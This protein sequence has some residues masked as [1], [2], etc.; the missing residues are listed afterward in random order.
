MYISGSIYV[1]MFHFIGPCRTVMNG[2]ILV[3][4]WSVA[5][6]VDFFGILR[7]FFN[8]LS[9]NEGILIVPIPGKFPRT[10]IRYQVVSYPSKNT[11]LLISDTIW[12]PSNT[13]SVRC[14]LIF[15]NV[16][17]LFFFSFDKSRSLFVDTFIGYRFFPMG[18]IAEISPYVFVRLRDSGDEGQ[19]F[20]FLS[21]SYTVCTPYP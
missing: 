15:T 12:Y 19:S 4:E 5:D 17:R 3:F 2:C 18:R 10:L 6:F 9:W 13:S 16:C 14:R 20:F 1:F 8:I 21:L 11:N 7:I